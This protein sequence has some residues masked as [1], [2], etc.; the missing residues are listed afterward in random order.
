MVYSQP[1]NAKKYEAFVKNIDEGQY[2]DIFLDANVDNGTLAQLA[3]IHK[4]CRE[5]ATDTGSTFEDMKFDVKRSAG[6]CIKKEISGEMYMICKSF[7]KCSKDELSLTIQAIIEIGNTVGID[8][9]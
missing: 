8:F 1:D 7:S 6:L 3:K 4:C 9:T 2:V 5:L